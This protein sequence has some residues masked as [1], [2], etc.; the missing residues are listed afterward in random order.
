LKIRVLFYYFLS[1]LLYDLTQSYFIRMLLSL[2]APPYK[3][4]FIDISFHSTKIPGKMC[5]YL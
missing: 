2:I 5:N 4:S 1:R 3:N